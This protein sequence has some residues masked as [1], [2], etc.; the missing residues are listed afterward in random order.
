MKRLLISVCGCIAGLMLTWT[1]LYVL[2]QFEWPVTWNTKRDPNCWDLDHCDHP[3]IK[4]YLVLILF[5][6][7]PSMYFG[8][9]NALAFARW[10][11][12]RWAWANGI[13]AVVA[14]AGYYFT[15]A[16]PALLAA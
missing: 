7:G 12:R 2:S 6:L 3:S 8:V 1:S 16:G 11:G 15:F 10:P 4:N 5:F 13:G 14:I 9:V